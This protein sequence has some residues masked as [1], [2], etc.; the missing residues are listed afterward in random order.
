MA[1][2]DR[3]RTVE[4]P[5]GI[6]HTA[7][8]KWRWPVPLRLAERHA[9][10]YQ[11]FM[12]VYISSLGCHVGYFA[13]LSLQ[14]YP[15]PVV[16]NVF[17]TL[18]NV[19]AIVLHRKGFLNAGLLM[20]AVPMSIKAA[21]WEYQLGAGGGFEYFHIV[22]VFF[23]CIAPMS[24]FNR[25]V[26]S[27]LLLL[28]YMGTQYFVSPIYFVSYDFMSLASIVNLVISATF[29]AVVAVQIGWEAE[30]REKRYRRDL[31]HDQL[32]GAL[33]RFALQEEGARM[34]KQGGLGV[35]MIDVD[36]FKAINDTQ[37]HAIGDEVLVELTQRLRHHL[38]GS[39]QLCRQG[40]EEFVA[41]CPSH[42]RGGLRHAAERL[43]LSINSRAFTLSNGQLLRVTISIGVAQ[44]GPASSA[45]SLLPDLLHRADQA[46]YSAKRQGRNRVV[47]AW[48]AG[49]SAVSST[50]VPSA[51]SS[52]T[53]ESDMT[54][55][56]A[57]ALQLAP[58]NSTD[59]QRSA[60]EIYLLKR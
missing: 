59:E 49:T 30:Q 40:G 33:S 5:K 32:T 19:L 57:S 17:G 47:S 50:I 25:L 44:G 9:S 38:R 36:H 37:G 21:L 31:R 58:R 29:I 1:K 35:L 20:L 34:L 52:N 8:L 4:R 39:D 54:G 7:L 48:N 3:R 26:F 15:Q 51:S 46:M 56:G 10:L 43:L 55:P 23:I 60:R 12:W 41:L 6:F 24:R 18:A 16:I 27:G 53:S 11:L 45:A 28:F 2:S 42:D 14:P 22:A 13:L